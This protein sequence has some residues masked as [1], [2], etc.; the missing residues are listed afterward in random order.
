M[1]LPVDRRRFLTAAALT[2]G[3]AALPRGFLSGAA[4]AAGSPRL[5]PPERGI[6]ATGPAT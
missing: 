5:T 4:A 6:Y 1:D 2:A 3:A